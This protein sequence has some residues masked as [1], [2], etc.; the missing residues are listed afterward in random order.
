MPRFELC[1]GRTQ[2]SLNLKLFKKQ[3]KKLS[4]PNRRKIRRI[5]L[6]EKKSLRK[7]RKNKNLKVSSLIVKRQ[8]RDL[9]KWRKSV[10]QKML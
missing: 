2:G 6:R 3:I 4:N 7:G 9:Q 1:T 5:R 8:K 10:R